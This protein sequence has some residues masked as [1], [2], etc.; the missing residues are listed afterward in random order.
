MV[1]CDAGAT[2]CTPGVGLSRVLGREVEAGGWSTDLLPRRP[3]SGRLGLVLRAAPGLRRLLCVGS[4]GWRRSLGSVCARL[5]RLRGHAG[6]RPGATIS[7]SPGGFAVSGPK[8]EGQCS[9]CSCLACR[10][11]DVSAYIG[12]GSDPF[13]TQR[14]RA[15]RYRQKRRAAGEV[16]RCPLGLAAADLLDHVSQEGEQIG[17]QDGRKR[18]PLLGPTRR[19]LIALWP[20]CCPQATSGRKP[21]RGI[22]RCSPERWHGG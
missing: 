2:S 14:A 12:Q 11:Q 3:A 13:E 10:V 8:T 5:E 7:G 18:V 21:R 22:L 1:S 9:L 15:A 20:C 16:H 17:R 19:V 6:L 4:G